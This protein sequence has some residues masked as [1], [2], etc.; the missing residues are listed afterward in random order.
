MYASMVLATLLENRIP[1]A[2]MVFREKECLE[3]LGKH[4][5]LPRLS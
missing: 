3:F 1:V 5:F 2:F 4:V